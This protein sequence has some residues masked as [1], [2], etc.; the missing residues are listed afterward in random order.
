MWKEVN[1]LSTISAQNIRQV[2]LKKNVYYRQ[3]CCNT[4]RRWEDKTCEGITS[5]S[6]SH[7]LWDPPP[8]FRVMFL[9]ICSIVNRYCSLSKCKIF[10]YS[11]SEDELFSPP[12]QVFGFSTI[13]SLFQFWFTLFLIKKVSVVACPEY[14]QN[15]HLLYWCKSR[16]NIHPGIV[17]VNSYTSVYLS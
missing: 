3:E 15:P 17:K 5:F 16:W 11:Q 8:P 2:Q 1:I 7:T 10:V 14:L 4:K 12:L 13:R 6:I 9:W